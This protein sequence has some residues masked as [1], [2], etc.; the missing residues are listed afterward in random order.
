MVIKN[1]FRPTY[2]P[3]QVEAVLPC[4]KSVRK[5]KL[6]AHLHAVPRLKMCEAFPSRSLV[7]WITSNLRIFLRA[8]STQYKNCVGCISVRQRSSSPKLFNVFD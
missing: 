4:H 2:I 8:L 1:Y 6:N 3:N 5:T 7:S